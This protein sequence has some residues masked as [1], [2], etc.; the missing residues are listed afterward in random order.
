MSAEVSFLLEVLEAT[1]TLKQIVGRIQLAVFVVIGLTSPFSSCLSARCCTQL[2]ELSCQL[3]LSS[4]PEHI[5]GV[6]KPLCY[7]FSFATSLSLTLVSSS[8]IL[9]THVFILG[10]G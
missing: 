7:A 2:L 10:H 5:S 6:L 4:N 8:L 3:P 1:F 9:R